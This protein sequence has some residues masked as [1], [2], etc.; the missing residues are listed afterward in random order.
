MSTYLTADR[1]GTPTN[2]KKYT[3][4]GWFKLSKTTNNH[5]LSYNYGSGQRGFDLIVRS[6]DS[7]LRVND[8][9]AGVGDH[10]DVRTNR[11]FKDF[12][13]WYHLVVA[14]DSTQGTAADRVKVYVNGIQ[15]TSFAASTYPSQDLDSFIATTP[16]NNKGFLVGALYN[17]SGNIDA[18]NYFSGYMSQFIFI[19]GTA[20]AASA[21]GST[22]SNG[23]WVPNS[24]PSVTYGTNGFKLDMKDSGASAAAGNFGADS[25]GNNNHFTSNGLGTN[26]NTKDSP[27]N[28]FCTMDP[29]Q[30]FYTASN[31]FAEGALKMTADSSRYEFANATMG[32][33][34]GKWY[35]EMKAVSKSGGSDWYGT[36]VMVSSPWQNDYGGSDNGQSNL[37]GCYY[38]GY[39]QIRT[40]GTTPGTWGSF[41]A[42]D[43]VSVAM[44][45][46]NAAI[47][48]AKNGVWQ[49]SGV[50]TSGASKTG[51]QAL[52]TPE[53]RSSG[54]NF[55]VPGLCYF[56]GGQSGVMQIN[57]GQPTFTIASSNSDAN[58]YGSFEYAVPSGYYA[59]CSKNIGQY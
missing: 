7:T 6:N 18:G 47:Y 15:E 52:T 28:N 51:A 24:S 16:Q 3:I 59:I 33:R 58:G 21:F 27:Q 57:F 9:T 48:F 42:G 54:Y 37:S 22:N 17:S 38:Y 35:W 46:D 11:V 39:G 25:S 55:W 29:D 4:A 10:V 5:I 49:N 50:P 14:Y 45:C 44:D 56:D 31:T 32:V 41:T 43:I 2:A 34:T 36:G 40:N 1:F 26:P 12:S 8:Y 13:A 23:V 53:V 20:Y 30:G 19:D